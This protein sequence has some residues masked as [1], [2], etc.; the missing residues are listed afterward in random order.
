[1]VGPTSMLQKEEPGVRA[2]FSCCGFSQPQRVPANSCWPPST[3]DPCLWGVFKGAKHL[4]WPGLA[5]GTVSC[6]PRSGGLWFQ[7]AGPSSYDMFQNWF[8]SWALTE[9]QSS[10]R[11]TFLGWA[12]LFLFNP[13]HT[14][15]LPPFTILN[16]G[17]SSPSVRSLSLDNGVLVSVY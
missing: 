1:M 6:L 5:K 16:W 15:H 8:G 10:P 11:I 3:T 17:L 14:A 2:V 13:S 7:S 9:P 12:L 4:P